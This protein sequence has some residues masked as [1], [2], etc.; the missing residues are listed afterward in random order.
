[1][2]KEK[3]QTPI[4][5]LQGLAMVNKRPMLSNTRSVHQSHDD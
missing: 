2:L 4:I 1:M 5:Y 3:K